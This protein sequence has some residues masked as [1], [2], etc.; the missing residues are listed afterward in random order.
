MA[1]FGSPGPFRATNAPAPS[2]LPS[3][4]HFI[5]V[6]PITPGRVAPGLEQKE[7]RKGLAAFLDVALF[8]VGLSDWPASLAPG[9]SL[10]PKAHAF[11]LGGPAGLV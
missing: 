10:S 11:D 4:S 5:S 9:W 2:P 1:L 7:A 3:K 8:F 6:M